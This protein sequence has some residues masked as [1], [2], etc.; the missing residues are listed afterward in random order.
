MLLT[1]GYLITVYS[2][3]LIEYLGLQIQ[4]TS[5]IALVKGRSEPNSPIVVASPSSLSTFVPYTAAREPI[6]PRP[7]RH[8]LHLRRA[9]LYKSPKRD[10]PRRHLPNPTSFQRRSQIHS[11]AS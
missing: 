1:W 2:T 7:G 4:N 5:Q 11:T 6:S 8:P 10:L 9:S 3:H